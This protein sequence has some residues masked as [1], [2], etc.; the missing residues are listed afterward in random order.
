MSDEKTEPKEPEP[1]EPEKKEGESE[2]S[3][4]LSLI[5]RTEKAVA[6]LKEQNDRSEEIV[7]RAEKANSDALLGGRADAGQAPAKPEKLSD[8][9]YAEQ[10]EKGEVNPL[11]ED[12]FLK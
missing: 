9:E 2:D 3:S 10:L 5:E 1:S 4:N 6:A 12:G 8:K 11:K 7:K